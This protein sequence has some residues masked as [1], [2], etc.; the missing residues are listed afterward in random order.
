MRQDLLSIRL[1]RRQACGS[2]EA[3]G[4]NALVLVGFD[5]ALLKLSYRIL[6]FKAP[7]QPRTLEPAVLI[8]APGMRLFLLITIV[9]QY[10]D[11]L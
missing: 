8:I 10:C 11:V 9:R 3:A 4:L 7:C 5:V 1:Y 2:G 6:T